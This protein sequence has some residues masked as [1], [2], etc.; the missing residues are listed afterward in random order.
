[1]SHSLRN[2]AA[3]LLLALLVHAAALTALQGGWQP[4]QKPELQA[5]KPQMVRSQL[6]VLQPKTKPKPAPARKPAPTPAQP[7]PRTQPKP[8]PAPKPDTPKVD[9]EAEKQ[10]QAAAEEQRRL[11]ELAEAAFAE[12]LAREA[13][14]LARDEDAA[15]AQSYRLGIYEQ[16][17]ANWSRPPSARNGMEAL[18]SVDLIPTGDVVGVTIEK[19]SGSSAFDRSAE[20]AVRKAG[21][22]HVPK[23]SSLFERHFRRFYLLFRPE[24]LLR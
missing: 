19:S 7:K 21:R 6:I 23:E 10:S 11:T 18:L 2:Y 1:M 15:K 20:A 24:D 13:A 5:F 3:P 16:V 17:V 9:R 4:D 22:F 12:T 8:A 14:D